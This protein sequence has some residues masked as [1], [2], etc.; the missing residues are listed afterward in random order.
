[1]TKKDTKPS[2]NQKKTSPL[3]T[4][5]AALA[6]VVLVVVS[7]ITGID[8]VGMLGL[9]GTPTPALTQPTARPTSPPAT[10]G[11]NVTPI[12]VGQG[13]G[14]RKGF[15]EVYFT[16]PTGSTDRSTYVGGIDEN[17][18]AAIDAARQ[19][20]DIAAFELNSPAITRALLDAHRRGVR[21]R[22]VADNEHTIEDSNSTMRQLADAGIPIVYDQ[23]SAFMHNK[24]IIIDS[25]TVWTGST[26]W[27]INDV[28]RNNNNLLMLR[29][30]RAV[31]VY[32][33]E[34]NEMF[35]DRQFGVRSNPSN[36]AN[37]TQDG[38][39]I[40]ILFAPENAVMD[41]IINEVMQARQ[42]VR[43]MAFSYTYP[44]LREAMLRRGREGITISGVFERRGSETQFSELTP[45]FCAGHD[46][47]QDGNNFTMHHKVI[48]VDDDTVITG[49]FNF[50]NNA[51][52]NNDENL[53][54]M[55]DRDLAAQYLAEFERVMAQAIVPQ[56][57]TCN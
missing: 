54:I 48:I 46:V 16:A 37:Y 53:V 56:R 57:L 14:A 29:S 3:I 21:V 50:S 31:E 20:L 10:G 5:L 24:F 45:L 52:R 34:F 4:L 47:R 39:P 30:R 26:N 22:V 42:S 32:Q 11:G 55:K 25:Q 17:V 27:T 15:W 18:A 7:Q 9:G 43:F 51:V 23:R 1:M 35:V 44:D 33:A 13:F 28:Y 19:T 38:T 12:P 40:I 8:F 2:G 36:T 6:L 41:S 49:S